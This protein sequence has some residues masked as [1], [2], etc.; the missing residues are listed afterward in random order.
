M[1]WWGR[2][3]PR[4]QNSPLT[5]WMWSFWQNEETGRICLIPL[6]RR[7]GKGWVKVRWP[8]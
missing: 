6:L 4:L 3:V 5:R 8:E 7:P 2:V 1:W